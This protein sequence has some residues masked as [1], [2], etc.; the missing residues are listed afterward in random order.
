[1]SNTVEILK[2]TYHIYILLACKSQV[3]IIN[4]ICILQKHIV[5]HNDFLS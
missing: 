1:M 2:L 5:T 4:N 3:A